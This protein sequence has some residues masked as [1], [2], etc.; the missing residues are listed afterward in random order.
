MQ[1]RTLGNTGL[2]VSA[3]GLGCAQLG[4]STTEYAIRVVRR[5][6]DLG[7]TYIDL[8]RG[9][10]DAEIKVGLALRGSA[11]AG[12]RERL[13][14]STKTSRRTREDA[15]REIHESLE[16]LGADYLDNVHLHGL[17]SSEDIDQRLGP[18]GAME[19]LLEARER[20]LVRHIGCSSHHPEVLV[21]AVE[22]FPF[23]IVLCIL[24]LVEREAQEALLPVC[25]ERGVA[26]TVMKPLA[27]G[28]LPSPL[29]LQWLLQEVPSPPL[30]C[31]V[32][33]ATTIEEVEQ[34]A[35]AGYAAPPLN[36]DQWEQVRALQAEYAHKRCRLCRRCE[37]CPSGVPLAMTL[38]TDVMYDHYR[39]MGATAFRAFP[40]SR[41]A[42]EGDI[43]SRR[44]LMAAIETCTHCG[45]C[46]QKCP[47]NLP[48]VDMLE[49]QLG[50]MRHMMEM[51]QEV[52][53]R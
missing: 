46:E 8:A 5:A 47:H 53:A 16:R 9:Y 42:V 48:I 21:E 52:L 19:A 12:E 31:P 44:K 7:V 30:V 11:H 26:V 3:I 41:A 14:I 49:Q 27:T 20:G 25:R 45:E 6:L 24:N 1:V 2:Q 35:L 22:R 38:G 40:W 4:S 13:F 28:L 15:W 34:N 29:A 43:A 39:T 51:Y 18:G 32:P 17:H 50:G 23:E 33:G 10:R 37:P 36:A